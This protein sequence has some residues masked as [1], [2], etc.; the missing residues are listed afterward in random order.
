MRR[1]VF[2][3]FL[4]SVFGSVAP[5]AV[6]GN[7][8]PVMSQ[9]NMRLVFRVLPQD[10]GDRD[11]FVIVGDGQYASRTHYGNKDSHLEFNVAGNV[12][13]INSERFLVWCEAE[14]SFD[15]KDGSGAFALQSGVFVIPG[16][17]TQVGSMG[18]KVLVVRLESD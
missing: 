1:L 13:R 8:E 16:K 18:D 9:G 2:V 14:I 15:G 7:E 6:E 11:V 5:V 10:E 12:E 3:A 17:D 4:V